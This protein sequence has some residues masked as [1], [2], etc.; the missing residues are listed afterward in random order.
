M[1]DVNDLRKGITFL[2]DNDLYKVLDYNF[3]K[4]GRGNATIR[5]KGRNLRTGATIERTFS[6]GERVQDARLEYRNV[7]F[8]YSDGDI[9]YFMDTETYE[10]PGVQKEMLGDYVN[11]LKEG[12]EVK[13]TYYENKPLDAEMP[14]TVDLKVISANPAV[15]GDTATSVL[16]RITVETGY[17]LNVPAFVEEG[18]TIRIDTRTGE[19]VTRV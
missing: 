1:I 14:T 2:I 19:Y 17:A 5:I 7:Q 13:L 12:V 4:P 16:K 15:K 11:Y 9:Y 10:Q 18:N 6:S 3:N 8:L